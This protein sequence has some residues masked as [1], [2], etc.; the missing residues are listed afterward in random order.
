MTARPRPLLAVTAL[1]AAAFGLGCGATLYDAESVPKLKCG[2]EKPLSCGFTCL[3][4]S[5]EADVQCGPSCLDCTGAN[6]LSVDTAATNFCN[7]NDPDLANHACDFECDPAS[8][9]HKNVLTNRCDCSDALQVRCNGAGTC[10]A[11]TLN[12]CGDTCL[13][14]SDAT[15]FPVPA[16]GFSKCD[17]AAR[18]CG[19]DCDQN[20]GFV[21]STAG[22]ACVCS[23]GQ[24]A[25]GNA[26]ATCV[27]QS[28]TVCGASCTNC[29]LFPIDTAIGA[30]SPRCGGDG[31]GVASTTPCN[32]SCPP[33][34]P[35]KSFD[36][37][38]GKWTCSPAICDVATQ[39]Q[40][41][42][43]PTCYLNT[44]PLHCLGPS[45]CTTCT[46][47]TGATPSCVPQGNAFTCS[48]NCP[49]GTLKQ[50]N[51]CVTI[52]STAGSVALG[53]DHTCVITSVGGL[54]CW[55]SNASG[56]LGVGTAGDGDRLT[57]VDVP[58]PAGLT[59]V[60]VAAGTTRTCAIFQDALSAKFIKCWG[61]GSAAMVDVSGVANPFAIAVGNGHSCAVGQDRVVGATPIGTVKC[62][63][64]NDKGQLGRNTVAPSLPLTAAGNTVPTL[65]NIDQLTTQLDHTCARENATNR[66]FCWG[67]NATAQT[68]QTASAA[69]LQPTLVAGIGASGGISVGGGHSCA[70][71]V[72]N[73]AN[74]GTY[75]WGA[76][77]VAQ[78][79]DKNV[80]ATPTATPVLAM[81]TQVGKN[82]ATIAGA[83][84]AHTCDTKVGDA[85]GNILCGGANDFFQCGDNLR[86]P[87]L[88]GGIDIAIGSPVDVL[89][90]GGDRSCALTGGV[91]KC[92][93]ANAHGQL[94]NNSRTDVPAVAPLGPVPPSPQ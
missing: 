5:A 68:G 2:A 31:N 10:K 23:A 57:Q 70:A 59:P 87:A 45:G 21:K 13:D 32:Y 44:D 6:K 28:A 9:L 30:N 11:Q 48:F 40:C 29:S 64:A 72:L 80:T 89:V 42:A 85:L 36:E 49:A 47:P 27:A 46:A 81:L 55:G 18:A 17:R 62:W 16:H 93:G 26:G 33:T 54:K 63:G 19:F 14:C 60:Y 35:T 69:T 22:D 56:Q 1:A 75:C 83:G 53:R 37:A 20:N 15:R 50:G 77:D 34:L 90:L 92:W 8:G 24:V 79:G 61:D 43:D 65:G 41:P 71:G 4:A 82:G 67:A 76:D 39:H 91:L 7:R 88:P 78:L 86:A 58:A 73:G 3:P 51:A 12:S 66:V 84:R 74:P 25:C 38:S 94:G 52:A